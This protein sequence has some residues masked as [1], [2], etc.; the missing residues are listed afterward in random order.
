MIR[1]SIWVDGKSQHN[2]SINIYRE[3]ITWGDLDVNGIKI[4]G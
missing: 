2:S 4:Y 3:D 1:F